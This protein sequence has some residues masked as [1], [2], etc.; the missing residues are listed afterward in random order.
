MR[1]AG[2]PPRNRRRFRRLW[3][4]RD[5]ICFSVGGVGGWF[6]DEVCGL[7]LWTGTADGVRVWG[8]VNAYH[9]ST[10]GLDEGEF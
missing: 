6:V 1:G 7:G 5:V 8:W 9:E 3:R 4:K 2:L 10:L